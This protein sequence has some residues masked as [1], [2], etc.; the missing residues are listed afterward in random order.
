VVSYFGRRLIFAAQSFMNRTESVVPW[1]KVI[2]WMV[3]IFSLSGDSF[4]SSRT[5]IA[6]QYWIAFFDLPVSLPNVMLLH[7]ALR[8][9]A[10]FGEFFVLGVLL[11]RALSGNLSKFRVKVACGVLGFGLLLALADE[12]RQV[13]TNHRAPS[14]GDSALDFAGVIASQL[15]IFFRSALSPGAVTGRNAGGQAR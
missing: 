8:N 15:W 9:V 11:Y 13:F 1:A 7:G 14:V 5:L 6:L 12:F 2:A 10:H 3:L 4:Q